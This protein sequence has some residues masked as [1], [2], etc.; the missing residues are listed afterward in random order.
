MA[1]EGLQAPASHEDNSLEVD[2]EF[3]A[4]EERA[5]T[6]VPIGDDAELET[7]GLQELEGGE[8]VVEDVPGF[9]LREVVV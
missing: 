8:N 4:V 3:L 5:E 6:F 7:A 9:G 1:G 2:V